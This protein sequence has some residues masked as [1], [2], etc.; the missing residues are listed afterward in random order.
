MSIF[1]F[2]Y[3]G[4]EKG[5]SSQHLPHA[6][7]CSLTTLHEMLLFLCQLFLLRGCGNTTCKA[8]GQLWE[9][10]E[11][12]FLWLCLAIVQHWPYTLGQVPPTSP[13]HHILSFHLAPGKPLTV[14]QM[15]SALVHVVL[16]C[17]SSYCTF[18]LKSTNQFLQCEWPHMDKL[19]S[20]A[21]SHAYISVLSPTQVALRSYTCEVSSSCSSGAQERCWP[22][23][24]NWGR[25]AF[26]KCNQNPKHWLIIIWILNRLNH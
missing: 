4:A 1:V 13:V 20:R 10:S 14:E 19:Q 11:Q 15:P 12:C 17:F 23:A 9:V 2:G 22:W 8:A 7:F 26:Q 16:C 5:M 24:G 6:V 3:V 25:F 18:L 21:V